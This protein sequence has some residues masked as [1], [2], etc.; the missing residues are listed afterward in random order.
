MKNIVKK[1]TNLI[2]GVL[3]VLCAVI[4]IL[5][6]ATAFSRQNR[7]D[8]AQKSSSQESSSEEDVP[9]DSQESRTGESTASEAQEIRSSL[10]RNEFPQLEVG[11]DVYELE[12]EIL[13]ITIYENVA[14]TT[15]TY[16]GS[17]FVWMEDED[18]L[19]IATA[20]HVLADGNGGTVEMV[21][22]SEGWTDVEFSEEDVV[23]VDDY[24]LALIH[25]SAD[26]AE[27]LLYIPLSSY[28]ASE[29]QTGDEGW[30]VDS[31]YGSGTGIEQVTVANPLIY[32]EDYGTELLYLYGEGK[33]GM[34]GSPVYS[35]QGLLMGMVC[36]MS[37]DGTELAAV[38]VQVLEEQLSE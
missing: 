3:L 28:I 30:I 18:G 31:I 37:E 24:D 6:S 27:T 32:F 1:K 23:R 26:T 16:S 14:V 4:V 35:A 19:W 22:V 29:A 12:N 36:G 8:S 25:L 7:E 10:T 38:P 34:S 9:D 11:M 13:A 2:I 33:E 5:V 15:D 20:A 21:S 17:G